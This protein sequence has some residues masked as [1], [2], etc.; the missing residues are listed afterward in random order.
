MSSNVFKKT[1][2][3]WRAAQEQHRGVPENHLSAFNG[4]VVPSTLRCASMASVGLAQSGR[5]GKPSGDSGLGCRVRQRSDGSV[6]VRR[7]ISTAL[8]VAGQNV[9]IDVIAY[10]TV[11]AVIGLVLS[12]IHI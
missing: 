3:A 7:N 12:L 6:S 1:C 8:V 10:L 4:Q 2:H 11:I 9:G 5:K